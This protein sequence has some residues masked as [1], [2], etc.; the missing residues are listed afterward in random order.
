MSGNRQFC[1][2]LVAVGALAGAGVWLGSDRSPVPETPV[3][4]ARDEQPPTKLVSRYRSVF[5]SEFSGSASCQECHIAEA[6]SFN[7]TPHSHSLEM[8]IAED[9]PSDVEFAH[10]ASRRAYRVFRRDGE[11]WHQEIANDDQGEISLGEFPVAWRIGSGH[12][13]RS[14]L[15][16]VDGY[17]FESPVT[18]YSATDSWGMSPG[19][20]FRDHEGF[21]RAAHEGCVQCHASRVESA[22]NSTHHLNII[23]PS[24]G[25]E[26]CHGPGAMHVRERTSEVSIVGEFD[27][28]IVRPGEQSREIN[29]A[30]CARCHLRGA[31]WSNVR[32]R[33]SIDF[34]PGLLMTDFRVDFAPE[35]ATGEMKVVG[36][37]EQMHASR[38]YIESDTL[39][40]TTCH[41]PHAAPSA[42]MKVEYYQRKCLSCHESEDSG[43]TLPEPER[44]AESPVDNCVACHMPESGTDIPHFS[45]THH[46]I[47]IRHPRQHDDQKEETLSKLVP[48]GDVSRLS[49]L[50]LE[51]CL[52]RAWLR[53]GDSLKTRERFAAFDKAATRLHRVYQAGMQDAGVSGGL[54]YLHWIKRDP[55]CIDFAQQALSSPDCTA[56]IRSDS[57][58]VL[59]DMHFERGDVEAAE[60]AFDELTR[61]R[62]RYTDWQMLGICRARLGKIDEAILALQAA[63]KLK[64]GSVELHLLLATILNTAGQKSLAE[65]H[66]KIAL[67]LEKQLAADS[68]QNRW[69]ESTPSA[70][71][72]RP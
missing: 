14:Y 35:N 33:S 47:A 37:F 38:C 16:D 41:N 11:L 9:E 53:Y 18:W 68:Q 12:H 56:K 55:V 66:R 6:R 69:P 28:T 34:R 15:I 20:D 31:G 24:I 57:L 59:G 22:E 58:I 23:E 25:C 3:L 46:C 72:R 1:L 42:E 43:C 17:L 8:V 44:L 39:T 21:S 45:F 71:H 62:L 64:P 65:T 4:P 70:N 40:C 13:S 27:D 51:R 60:S 49:G 52:G 61:L 67:R 7:Q 29:E 30:I 10:A 63:V 54:A 36:H 2:V 19:Y 50:D 32:G 48:I 5:E 26:S